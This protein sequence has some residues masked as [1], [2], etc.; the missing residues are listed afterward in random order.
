M[1]ILRRIC[2]FCGSSSG[3]DS[4]YRLAAEALARELVA[5]QSAL[6]YG[7]SRRGLMGALADAAL[8][9]QGEVIG[10]IPDA[11]VG[12]E[13]AHPSLTKLHVVRSMHERKALM[14]QLS[15]AV[16]ALPGGY[17]TL[18]EFC[19]ILT[20]TQLGFQDKPCGLLNTQ[21]YFDHLLRF[22]DHAVSEGF[23]KPQHRGMLLVDDHPAS[24]LHQLKHWVPPTADK[25]GPT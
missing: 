14:A 2:V 11:M 12:M 16:V 17:G 21:G 5:N 9:A 25:L 22:L 10:V 3:V 24:L 1:K 6:V 13:V 18:D 7:G 15:D 19:E 20:W 23:L 8:K 4:G